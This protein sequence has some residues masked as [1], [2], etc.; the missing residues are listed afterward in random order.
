MLSIHQEQYAADHDYE[1]GED[2]GD[3]NCPNHRRIKIGI[4]DYPKYV[5]GDKKT[6]SEYQ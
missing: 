1:I 5:S 4:R 6:R 3:P 2:A